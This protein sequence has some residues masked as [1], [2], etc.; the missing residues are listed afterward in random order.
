[1]PINKTKT[2]VA[3]SIMMLGSALLFFF[4]NHIFATRE[5]DA[6]A[7]NIIQHLDNIASVNNT[8]FIEFYRKE[9]ANEISVLADNASESTIYQNKRFVLEVM[10]QYNL[11][12][13][14]Y[15]K[16]PSATRARLMVNTYSLG[17]S[18]Y[19][20]YSEN[21]YTE[22]TQVDSINNALKTKT[23]FYHLCEKTNNKHWFFCT[24][25]H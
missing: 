1:M 23:E 16:E 20:Q 10:N 14:L 5:L 2:I 24:S 21:G 4:A 17:S 11:S 3:L 13:V 22:E 15:V 19:Y 6:N 25:S 8:N 9:L 18:W 12:R 7:Q